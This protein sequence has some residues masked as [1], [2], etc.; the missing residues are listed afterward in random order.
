LRSHCKP[1]ISNRPPTRRRRTPIGKAVSAGP[2][3]AITA[4]STREATAVPES[5]ERQLRVLPTAK[6]IV[7]AST[8]STALARKTEIARLAS[9]PLTPST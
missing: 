4:A 8:A 2:R 3:P 1:K 5:A 7:N 6:T 9:A